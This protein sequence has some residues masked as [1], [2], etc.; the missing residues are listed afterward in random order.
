[1]FELV[2]SK[3][4]KNSKRFSQVLTEI[5]DTEAH[6]I[7]RIVRNLL[8][9]P[10]ADFQIKINRNPKPKNIVMSIQEFQTELFEEIDEEN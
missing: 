4:K 7:D 8:D 2:I 5:V 1:M 3:K 10:D 9:N 6:V